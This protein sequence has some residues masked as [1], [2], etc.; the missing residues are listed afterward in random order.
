MTDEE[1]QDIARLFGARVV[2]RVP[3]P[4]HGAIGAANMVA[5][6]QGHL[7]K[8]QT[9]SSPAR[10]MN[11]PLEQPAAESLREM[12]DRFSTPDHPVSADQIAAALIDTVVNVVWRRMG[13]ARRLEDVLDRLKG[14][15]AP[16]SQEHRGLGQ[17]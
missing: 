5:F 10:T 9:A 7:E 2:G 14:M 1:A 16:T 12:A 11:V 4:L 6:H 8:K 15:A 3:G 17:A 13:N